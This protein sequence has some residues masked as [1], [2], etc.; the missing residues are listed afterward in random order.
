MKL[1]Y[2]FTLIS[3]RIFIVSL[4]VYERL[5]VA[6]VLVAQC[7]LL[8]VLRSL[9]TLHLAYNLEFLFQGVALALEGF[10]LKH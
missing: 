5:I 6:G 3:L 1:G 9:R 10:M 8:L 7:S 2:R 4:W